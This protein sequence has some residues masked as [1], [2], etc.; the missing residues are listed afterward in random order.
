M[1]TTAPSINYLM[2]VDT[3]FKWH[4]NIRLKAMKGFALATQPSAILACE[5]A[6]QGPPPSRRHPSGRSSRGQEDAATIFFLFPARPPSPVYPEPALRIPLQPMNCQDVR[7]PSGRRAGFGCSIMRLDDERA[8]ASLELAD[9]RDETI[10]N[11]HLKHPCLTLN[12]TRH[13]WHQTL[14]A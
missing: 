4:I 1:Q 7:R 13:P 12:Q 11:N 3:V 9:R 6:L 5:A 10:K 8:R 2:K 14:A